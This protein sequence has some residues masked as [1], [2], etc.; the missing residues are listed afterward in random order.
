MT[1]TM[2]VV[3][4]L[5][6]VSLF[7][8][9][10]L[11][12]GL[13]LASFAFVWQ[14]GIP[15]GI[16]P[17]KMAQAANSFPLLAAPLFILMGN[18]MNA[19]GVTERIFRFATAAVGW[20]RGGLCHANI[21]AS[22]IFAGMSGSAV[23]DA[24][25]IGTI[26]IKAMRDAGYDDETAASVTAASATIG[27][28]IP[29]SLPMVIYAVS[30]DVSIGALFLAGVIPGLL[31]A[32]ALMALVVVVSRRKGL[33]REPF[34][35]MRTLARAFAEAFLSLL[36]PVILFGGLISGLF[37]P[38][39]AAAVAAGYALLLGLVIYRSLPLAHLPRLLAETVETTGVVLALLM[40]AT[41][42]AWCLS[43]SRIPQMLGPMIVATVGDPLLFLL[44]VNLVL[45]LVGMVMEA[46]AAMLVLVP[47]LVPAAAGFG[48][49]PVHFG[50]IFVLNLMI[51]TITPPVGIVLFVTARIA[52]MPFD[53]LSRAI[54]P[55]LAPLVAVLLAVTLYPP[56][57]IWLPRLVLG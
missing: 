52:G 15:L 2:L 17:Q 37:T 40:T 44:A 38:T 50:L 25:G 7:L 43:L 3:L 48:I 36:T 5:W 26:E 57:A 13:G 10:P 12:A 34:P 41:A 39:E 53:R 4:G 6:L 28:I 31:M 32:G 21:L 45:L 55:W 51:G 18:V 22:V 33:P 47:I 46:I 16:V 56:L 14:A 9:L 1:E 29:P 49:D 27:P 35:G 24:G 20:L 8:G 11:F 42:L 30:A 54:V 19:S 23:A